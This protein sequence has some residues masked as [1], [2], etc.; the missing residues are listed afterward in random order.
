MLLKEMRQRQKQGGLRAREGLNG[1]SVKQTE[2]E[3]RN[4]D[5]KEEKE[6]FFSVFT[7]IWLI[8]VFNQ[9]FFISHLPA[10]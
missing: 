9:T 7:Q 8:L 4:E 10:L 3:V 6:G 5:R 1:R 2:I